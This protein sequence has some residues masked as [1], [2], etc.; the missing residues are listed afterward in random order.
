M[1]GKAQLK[2]ILTVFNGKV[3]GELFFELYLCFEIGNTFISLYCSI[4]LI[5]IDCT[6]IVLL[7]KS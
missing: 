2:T 1:I 6:E 4:I 3:F 5:A 7:K